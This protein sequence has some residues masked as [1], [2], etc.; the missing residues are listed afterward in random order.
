MRIAGIAHR[1]ELSQFD[2]S[3]DELLAMVREGAVRRV[4]RW[5]VKPEAPA[6]VVA[7]L[8]KG[9]RP[10]CIDGAA[11]LG[12]WT[13][14]VATAV[15]VFRPRMG[16]GRRDRAILPA[17]VDPTVRATPIRRN[18][19]GSIRTGMKLVP[20][21]FHGPS[22]RHWPDNQPVPPLSTVLEHCARCLTVI[23]AATIIESALE[24]RLLTRSGLEDLLTAL[25]RDARRALARVRSDAGSGTETTVRWWFES[26]RIKVR[27]Q[28]VI[29]GVGR[30]DLLVG[31]SWVIECDSHEFH[32]IKDQYENDRSRDLVLRTL[33]YTVT[34]LTWEQVF[35]TWPATAKMLETIYRRGDHRRPIPDRAFRA[36]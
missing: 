32:E 14:P 33:G 29:P 6:D 4:Q 24:K 27:S 22:L 23:Q 17:G 19:D 8:A 1:D 2:V 16:T 34:R 7:V 26:R 12:L 21:Q 15:H 28:V 10:T 13:P 18:R 31:D 20:L 25:P 36:A 5:Y 30:V 9:A 11:L 3:S 35:L